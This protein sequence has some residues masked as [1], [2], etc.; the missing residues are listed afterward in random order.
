MT[1]ASLPFYH[2]RR[3]L[4]KVTC[5][6]M[7]ETKLFFVWDAMYKPD[8]IDFFRRLGMIGGNTPPPGDEHARER[9]DEGLL[10]GAAVGGVDA[11]TQVE[12][13]W[14]VEGEDGEEANQV[15]LASGSGVQVEDALDETPGAGPS[16]AAV[17]VAAADVEEEAAAEVDAEGAEDEDEEEQEDSDDNS[18]GA[19]DETDSD[20]ES[21]NDDWPNV[22]HGGDL[23]HNRFAR[24]RECSFTMPSLAPLRLARI[25]LTLLLVLTVQTN[26]F[27]QAP[28]YSVSTSARRVSLRAGIFSVYEGFGELCVFTELLNLHPT[29]FI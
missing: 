13:G 1:F 20:S 8:N 18:A 16:T 22:P 14:D 23:P 6:Q 9:D 28:S 25:K 17:D 11:A 26:L 19:H 24:D 27:Q 7:T 10:A 21:D 29:I 15:V 3:Q 4:A 2:D 5:I 12:L